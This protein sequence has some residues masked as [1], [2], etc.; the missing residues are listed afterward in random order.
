MSAWITGARG[1]I[2][3]HLARHLAAGGQPVAGVG[4]GHWPATEAA[5]H[6]LGEW[7]NGEIDEGNL[8]L[9][10]ARAGPPTVIY[11]LAGGA[12]VGASLANPAE[13]YERTV[14]TTVRLLDW[15]R[16][17]CPEAAVIAVSSAA[18]YGAGHDR[19]IAETEVG[20][21]FSPYGHHK[22]MMEAVCRSYSQNFGVRAA[23]ARVFS[24]YGPGL[25]KQLLWD[26]CSR[27][28]TPGAELVLDGTGAESRDWLEVRDVAQA[29]ERIA[30][31]TPSDRCP[32]FNVGT[33]AGV[34]V[35]EVATLVL[36]AADDGRRLAFSGRTRSGDPASLVA[37]VT[38]LAALGVPAPRPLAAGVAGYVR[39]FR[40]QPEG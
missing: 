39:W 26:I 34:T 28:R 18:V 35:A 11:H 8:D 40:D 21:P 31:A 20:V 30:V 27:L 12:A 38:R 2:G 16:R 14:H 37:D 1:F 22:A 3:R 4:H 24:A 29:L 15:I 33:G 17:R 19:P 7:L 5:R 32:V 9:L 13:D 6:G 23:I 10:A 36:E 25:R